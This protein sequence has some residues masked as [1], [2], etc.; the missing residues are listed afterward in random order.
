MTRKFGGGFQHEPVRRSLS[1]INV[2]I[3]IKVTRFN[4]YSQQNIFPVGPWD[5]LG[6]EKSFIF[7]KTM[8]G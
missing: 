6:Q 5:F 7:P 4:L 3:K 1:A 8:D 2:V